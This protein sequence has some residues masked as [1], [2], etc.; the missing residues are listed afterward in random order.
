MGLWLTRSR[1]GTRK[2]CLAVAQTVVAA[3]ASKCLGHALHGLYFFALGQIPLGTA[4]A[5]TATAPFFVLLLSP[6][7]L[8]ERV[9]WQ[10]LMGVAVGF[11]GVCLITGPQDATA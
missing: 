1:A 8:G 7:V 11:L 6:H 5:L 3:P 10:R 4:A 2:V 9:P